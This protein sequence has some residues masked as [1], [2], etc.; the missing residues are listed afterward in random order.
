M[1]QSVSILPCQSHKDPASIHMC[2][3]HVLCTRFIHTD[4]FIQYSAF[5]P[6]S[7]SM[8]TMYVYKKLAFQENIFL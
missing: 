1:G 4:L 8:D 6:L 7:L 5:S 2:K 3:T